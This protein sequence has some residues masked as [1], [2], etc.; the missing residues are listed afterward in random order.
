[1]NSRCFSANLYKLYV[2]CLPFGRLFNLPFG[3][4]FNKVITQ[5][6]T[7]VML[8]G[9][10]IL[11]LNNKSLINSRNKLFLGM[12]SYMALSS[13]LMAIILS[14][15]INN[16]YESPMSSI[17]GDIV[18]YLFVVLSVFYN[19]YCLSNYVAFSAIYKVFNWQ[20]MVLLIVG[21][22]QFL[23][24]LGLSAP[25]NILSSIFSLRELSWL[26]DLDRGVTFFG[27]EPS[28]AAILCFVVIPYLYSTIQ[29]ERGFKRLKYIVALMLFAFLVLFSN[30]SQF[31][32]LFIGSASLFIWS[33]FRP[34]KK[35]F[36]YISFVVGFFFAFAYISADNVTMTKTTD[37]SSLEYV[38]LG[39]VVDRENMS[40]AM[41]ASTVINDL[42]VFTDYPITG[43]GDG[44]QGYFYAKNQPYWTL[45]SLEVSNL[46]M[47]HSIPNGGGNFFPSYI[48]AYG[49][50]GII[51][52]ILFITKYR[53]L[54]INS[55]LKNDKRID[56]IFQIAII[57]FL[58]AAWHVVGIKQSETI[59][60]VLS[61]PCV[62]LMTNKNN[63]V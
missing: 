62:K 18:L 3:D 12:Y 37:T 43:V 54:Y 55:F 33:C 40:T 50:V 32:I 61:L 63:Y 16:Q 42:K 8:L 2:L 31:L 59:I 38:I 28:S 5:F 26:E 17:V 34:I 51:V 56:T 15:I 4:F 14:F 7:L 6:S 13:I 36:Y 48:S 22:A 10:I 11:L 29:L 35:M 27:S 25:Y 24:M 57:L 39:K 9:C 60:F 47:T 23:G 19:C 52:F 44:N 58:F 21:Y 45:S 49:I 53:K 1:M 41:R 46:I 30:S 20:I